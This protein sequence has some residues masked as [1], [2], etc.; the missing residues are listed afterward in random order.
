MT[1]NNLS[2]ISFWTEISKGFYR[3]VIAANACYEIHLNFWEEGT[4]ILTAT[5]SLYITGSWLDE[6]N[7]S[8]LTREC[9]MV[10]KPVSKCLERAV[11][12]YKENN[13]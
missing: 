7:E 5:A 12:D 4:D 6:K 3:Y 9:L 10:N 2:N 8:F 13:E 1:M 11:K